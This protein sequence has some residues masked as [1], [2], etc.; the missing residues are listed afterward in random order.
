MLDWTRITDSTLKFLAF[1]AAREFGWR[2]D[3]LFNSACFAHVLKDCFGLPLYDSAV[4]RLILSGRDFILPMS[5]G[6]HWKLAC[7]A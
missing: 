5:G 4:I 3:G 6:S 1:L 2:D 7:H